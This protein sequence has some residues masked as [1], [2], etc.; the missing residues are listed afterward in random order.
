MPV[1][2]GGG[3]RTLAQME[4]LFGLGV[5]KVSL[6][7]VAGSLPGLVADA[8]RVFGRQSVVTCIDYQ[9]RAFRGATVVTEGGRV[10]LKLRPVDFARAVEDAGAGEILLQSV[11]RDGTSSGYDLPMIR[12]VAGSVSIPVIAC[13]GARDLADLGN[14]IS[15]GAS[16]AAAGSL[17]VFHGRL[18]A[19]L[20]SY[21]SRAELMKLMPSTS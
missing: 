17:F 15:H 10:D 9:R 1:C 2:Y 20:I 7:A 12:E 21:P 19:V 11:D 4:Q 13:G 3:V 18:R 5:E 6:G 8:A 14:A 16:A